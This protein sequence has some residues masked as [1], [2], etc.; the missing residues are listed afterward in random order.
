MQSQQQQQ[1]GGLESTT[2][3][4]VNM[5][6]IVIFPSIWEQGKKKKPTNLRRIQTIT[7]DEAL[8]FKVQKEK[9]ELALYSHWSL[10][11]FFKKMA[12]FL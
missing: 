3:L 12:M 7:R 1:W 10:Q 5:T 2:V 11:N 9:Q 8:N 4:F 6:A